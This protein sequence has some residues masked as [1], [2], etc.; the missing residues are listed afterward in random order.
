MV[1]NMIAN[2]TN[3][4]PFTLFYEL[5]VRVFV[6]V[7]AVFSDAKTLLHAVLFL[8]VIDQVIGVTYALK[9]KQFCWK[10]FNKVYRQ[11]LIYIAV[12][13]AAFVYERYLLGSDAIYFTK[14][15]A[16]LVGFQEVSSSYLTF[17]KM[18]GI[19]VFQK[20]FDKIK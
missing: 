15:M 3:S 14:I 4:D 1:R 20:V 11:V 16:A 9:E 13:L 7:L 8:I 10:V 18:T 5:I 12:I 6:A 19:Q 2:L 17:A